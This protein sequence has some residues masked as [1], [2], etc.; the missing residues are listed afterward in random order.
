MRVAGG[1]PHSYKNSST[2]KI[3]PPGRANPARQAAVQLSHPPPGGASVS[4]R[5]AGGCPCSYKNS[6]TKKKP[7]LGRADLARQAALLQYSCPSPHPGGASL[8]T[9][10]V[11]GAQCS[12]QNSSRKMMAPRE[13]PL[14]QCSCPMPLSEERRCRWGWAG[15]LGG[16]LGTTKIRVQKRIPN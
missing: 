11:G 5:V 7:P 10:V 2:K 9:G 3:P 8:P 15:W 16:T 1:C 13:E 12:Y 14:L 6:S 4:T